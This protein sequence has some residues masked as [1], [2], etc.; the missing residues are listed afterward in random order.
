MK[1]IFVLA[2]MACC[3]G[4]SNVSAAQLNDVQTVQV[5]E[6][7]VFEGKWKMKIPD[8][9]NGDIEMDIDIVAAEDGKLTMK[10]ELGDIPCTV[11][12]DTLKCEFDTSGVTVTFEI[13]AVD[14]DNLKGNVMDMFDLTAT[15]IKE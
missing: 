1:K 10:T 6:K 13:K 8:T 5:N 2:M 4:V 3:L 9:P 7:T 14:N 11:D 15:R 12:K